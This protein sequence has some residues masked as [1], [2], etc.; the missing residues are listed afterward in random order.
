M[1]TLHANSTVNVPR[2]TLSKM[3]MP[4]RGSSPAA[5]RSVWTTVQTKFAEITMAS[6]ALRTAEA[7]TSCI[8]N[9]QTESTGSWID[10]EVERCAIILSADLGPRCPPAG[11]PMPT[12]RS[13]R[14]AS[15]LIDNEN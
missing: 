4:K 14:R 12:L 2:M 1:K 6:K 7:N 9:C 8:H 10:L 13:R 11:L 15:G 3:A 5:S